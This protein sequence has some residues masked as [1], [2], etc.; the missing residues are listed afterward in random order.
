MPLQKGSC[1]TCTEL[2]NDNSKIGSHSRDW[3]GVQFKS[4]SFFLRLGL[5]ASIPS[6][7]GVNLAAKGTFPEEIGALFIGTK[8]IYLNVDAIWILAPD[9]WILDQNLEDISFD[10]GV[11]GSPKTGCTFRPRCGQKKLC[12]LKLMAKIQICGADIQ[13]CSAKIQLNKFLYHYKV[14]LSPQ[15]KCPSPPDWHP[16][17]LQ[18]AAISRFVVFRVRAFLDLFFCLFFCCY[19]TRKSLLCLPPWARSVFFFL[20][21]YFKTPPDL[22]CFFVFFCLLLYNPKIFTSPLALDSK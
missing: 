20:S 8:L 7:A 18:H 12:F 15:E 2:N 9:I 4:F 17:T 13:T 1:H 11:R 3:I 10:R 16:P 14:P 5:S 6:W 22:F 19:K 21:W